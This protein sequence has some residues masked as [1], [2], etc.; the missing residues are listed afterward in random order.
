MLKGYT[1]LKDVESGCFL[2]QHTAAHVQSC[3]GIPDVT[4]CFT[5]QNGRRSTFSWPILS[6]YIYIYIYIYACVFVLSKLQSTYQVSVQLKLNKACLVF[7]IYLLR[8]R[9]GLGANVFMQGE[10]LFFHCVVAQDTYFLAPG[11]VAGNEIQTCRRHDMSSS[12]RLVIPRRKRSFWDPFTMK[13]KK[14]AFRRNLRM[15]FSCNTAQ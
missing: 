3:W 6:M 10:F 2:H 7:R 4:Q 14:N 8:I 15:Q 1:N 9:L 11:V 12:L 13:T 5:V